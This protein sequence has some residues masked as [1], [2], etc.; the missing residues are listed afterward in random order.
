LGP[1]PGR[2]LARE[3]T[4][5]KREQEVILGKKIQEQKS[6]KKSREIGIRNES[7]R[8]FDKFT[9][10]AKSQ[11][12]EHSRGKHLGA[13]DCRREELAE[14]LSAL[15]RPEPIVPT[16]HIDGGEITGDRVI[17]IRDG[18]VSHGDRVGAILSDVQLTVHRHERVAILGA[19]GSGKTSLIR[20][21]LGDPA[22]R[23]WGQWD[24]LASG[25]VG[26][27]SQ[28]Y[29]NVNFEKSALENLSTVVPRWLSWEMRKHLSTFLFRKNEEVSTAAKFLSG[30]ERARLSLAL[31]A[32]RAPALLILDEI[33]NNIDRE[34]RDHVIDVLKN[35]PGAMLV[36]SH[37]ENFLAQ[38]GVH[39]R[40]NI[41]TRKGLNQ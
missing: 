1:A 32:A 24:V 41:P 35:F 2:G 20:A 27:L 29:A 33:T 9:A 36:V 7:S 22:V 21:I 18:V 19:N 4:T 17:T 38:I 8:K 25:Q 23:R 12:A 10:F 40:C 15:R 39:C 28:T 14:K 31:I 3:I 26:Y 5:L 6:A 16:F 37:D 34:T 13:L 30:G 11:W